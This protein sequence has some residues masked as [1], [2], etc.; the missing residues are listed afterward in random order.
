MSLSSNLTQDEIISI[1]SG[2]V[3]CLKLN[4]WAIPIGLIKRHLQKWHWFKQYTTKDKIESIIN[5]CA[6]L[7]FGSRAGNIDYWPNYRR[8]SMFA[9]DPWLIMSQ[10][11]FTLFKNST[12]ET[13]QILLKSCIKLVELSK[14]QNI[15]KNLFDV[16]LDTFLDDLDKYFTGNPSNGSKD[17]YFYKDNAISIIFRYGYGKLQLV[18]FFN[19]S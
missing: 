16:N 4:L 15:Q 19:K 17:L 6:K 14:T 11:F 10:H 13:Q 9:D 7:F 3:D 5:Q 8:F 2:M 18:T 1:K 12:L